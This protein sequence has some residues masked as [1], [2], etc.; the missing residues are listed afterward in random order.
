MR[1]LCFLIPLI[2]LL[3]WAPAAG[4][5][6]RQTVT[7]EAP[8]ELLSASTRD[9]TLDQIASFGI[10]RVRQLVYWSNYAPEPDSKTKPAGFDASNPAAYPA[11]KWDNL[12]GLVDA[13]A[14]RGVSVTLTLTGPVPKWATK[15]KKDQ[16]TDPLPAE[17]GAFATAIGRRYGDR[18]S[19]WS[20]WN[21]PN[22]PQFLKPQY[23]KG[24]PASPKLYRKLYQ[25]AY[26][27]IRSTPAN[28]K[29]TILLGETS[30]R[31]NSH[32]VH[33]LAFLRGTLCLDY[34]YRKAKSCK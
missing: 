3:A 12:D 4:A 29:D 1:R 23:V 24:K 20:I 11:D 18:V 27:G 26:A 21:E 25:A 9:A 33:P 28:A 14:A 19:T 22:Q 15:S 30:P 6:T 32:I 13:A 5:S 8:R 31:G 17:F 16:L 7:F 2:A 34:K 10:T